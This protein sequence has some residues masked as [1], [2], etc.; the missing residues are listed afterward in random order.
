MDINKMKIIP[1]KRG[2]KILSVYWFAILLITAGGIFAMVYIFYGTPY[3]VREI[4]TRI[5]TNQI[6]DCV[7]YEGKISQNL[8]SNGIAK[9]GNENFLDQCHLN[10]NSPEWKDAQFY[11]EVNLYKLENLNTPVLDIKKGNNNWVADCT[12]QEN[13][14]QE[15]LPTCLRKNFYSIDDKNNQYIIKILSVVRKAEKNVKI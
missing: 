4:E 3:D 12:I 8:I 14:K 10:F 5:L 11:T 6:A 15:N 2:D 13:K 9:E 1:N 7:S